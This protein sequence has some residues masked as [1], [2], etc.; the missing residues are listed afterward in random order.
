MGTSA[1]R[2]F[3]LSA[4]PIPHTPPARAWWRRSFVALA[5]V[6]LVVLP[7]P[8]KAAPA[9]PGDDANPSPAAADPTVPSLD[10]HLAAVA[11]EVPG[12]G[13]AF[14]KGDASVGETEQ[15]F[16]WLVD[17]DQNAAQRAQQALIRF[18]GPRFDQAVV[19]VLRAD[20]SFEQLKSWHEAMNAAFGLPG[21]VF[22]DVD[23]SR[24]RVLIGVEDV[25][26]LSPA[27]RGLAVER[28]VPEPALAFV[29]ATP[30]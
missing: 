28:G 29:Q 7:Q 6:V 4:I 5:A 11:G 17:P 12:F 14:V 8:S 20:F 26:T 13:G 16:I 30:F 22:T 15:L 19:E 10:D 18:L 3:H 21:V 24:N 9:G 2:P 1:S 23:E 25:E 27:I